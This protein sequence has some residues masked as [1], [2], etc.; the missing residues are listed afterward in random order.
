M[1]ATRH[2]HCAYIW[3]RQMIEMAAWDDVHC[4]DTSTDFD[5]LWVMSAMKHSASEHVGRS[6]QGG[7]PLT[8]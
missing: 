2:E 5:A 3:S 7:T 8:T 4:T 6:F 1:P